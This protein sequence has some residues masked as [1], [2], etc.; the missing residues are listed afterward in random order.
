MSGARAIED[1]Y[2]LSPIQQGILFHVLTAPGSGLY[3]NQSAVTVSGPFEPDAF[4]RAWTQLLGRHPA[5]RSG[6]HYENLPEAVQVVHRRVDA[7]VTRLDWQSVPPA[8]QARAFDVLAAADIKREFEM[9]RAPL[10]RLMMVRCAPNLWRLLW[11]RHHIMLDAWSTSI[12][13]RELRVLYEAECRGERPSL[14]AAVPFRDYLVWLKAQDRNRAESFW[15][16]QL[17]DA[18]PTPLPGAAAGHRGHTSHGAQR[19]GRRVVSDELSRAAGAFARAHRLTLSTL[20]Q[21]AWAI[22]LGRYGDAR[23]VMYGLTV[24]GRPSAVGSADAIVG[25]LINT[26]PVRVTL[27]SRDGLTAWL[28]DLQLRQAAV[29][30]FDYVSLTDIH[31]WSGVAADRPLFETIFVFQNTPVEPAGH[32]SDPVRF[33]MDDRGFIER[34]SYPLA[35]VVSADGRIRFRATYDADRL[36][37]VAVEELLHRLEQVLQA[38]VLNPDARP[39]R[40]DLLSAADRELLEVETTVDVLDTPFQYDS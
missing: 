38:M 18:T 12:L 4:E 27:D 24:A 17:R 40:L 28:R 15:R 20:V 3:V 31:R 6:I 2:P 19:H 30:E 34:N 36:A 29:R 5:L 1:I 39:G 32:S 13:A 25:P 22:L 26:I 23:H 10:T 37:G 11:T 8:R 33:R 16:E 21:G 14:R 9:T 35:L 7:N